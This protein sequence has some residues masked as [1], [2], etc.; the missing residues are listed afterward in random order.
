MAYSNC[1][2]SEA[3][4]PIES[5]ILKIGDNIYRMGSTF[6]CEKTIGE[7][8]E[9]AV[10]MWKDNNDTYY[11]RRAVD[12]FLP[13]NNAFEDVIYKA[14]TSSAVWA[15]G[16]SVICKVKTWCNGMGME[17]STLAF[18]AVNFPHIPVPDVV[19]SW[20]DTKLNRTFLLLKRIEGLTLQSAW[21]SLSS[22]HKQQIASTIA[23]Y[24]NDLATSRSSSFQSVTGLGVLEPFLNVHAETSH[25][26]WKPRLLGPFPSHTFVKYL[27]RIS[28]RPT[29]NFEDIFHLYHADLGPSNILVSQDGEVR[30]ILD[31]ESAAFYP[32]FWV[33][34]KPY[35]SAG[36]LLNS[37]ESRHEWVDLFETKLSEIGFTLDMDHVE[38]Y[39]SLDMNFFDIT[40]VVQNE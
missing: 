12:E 36:F 26:S 11:L 17:S 8:P 16:T 29:P 21:P 30:G 22:E 27:Q 39:K 40:E 3:S 10:T 7:L 20:L 33:S 1:L 28:K 15:F 31:W 35:I 5:S 25:P 13:E 9:S 4:P 2:Y 14:G 23:Q 38:W 24:C 18:L 6:I 34:L 19:F 32:D 37:N